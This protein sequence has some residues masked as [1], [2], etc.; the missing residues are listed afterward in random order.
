MQPGRAAAA[1]TAADTLYFIYIYKY[2]YEPLRAAPV[3]PGEGRK[4]EREG[5]K[6]EKHFC[7]WDAPLY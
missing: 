6:V 1:G 2:I 5:R 7:H 4:K 3:P